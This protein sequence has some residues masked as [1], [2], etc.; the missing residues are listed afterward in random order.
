MK[1]RELI[2][3]IKMLTGIPLREFS[4]TNVQGMFDEYFTDKEMGEALEVHQVRSQAVK[5]DK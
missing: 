4:K 5:K 1:P 2:V 3:T